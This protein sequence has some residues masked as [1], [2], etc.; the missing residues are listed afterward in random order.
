[1][2]DKNLGRVGAVPGVLVNC[3]SKE[4][5]LRLAILRNHNAQADYL[6]PRGVADTREHI[7]ID[8]IFPQYVRT[9]V[10]RKSI[11]GACV[12]GAALETALKDLVAAGALQPGGSSESVRKITRRKTGSEA[13]LPG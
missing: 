7:I 13:S 3:S 9:R 8:S 10:G 1:M 4:Q 5:F 12:G 6:K 11:G 2:H